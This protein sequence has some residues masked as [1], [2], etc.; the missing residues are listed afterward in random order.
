MRLFIRIVDGQP[1]EHPI[2]EDNMQMAFPE[3]NLDD[4]GPNFAL[5]ERYNMSSLNVDQFTQN[6]LRFDYVWQ[7]DKVVEVPVIVDKTEQE[8]TDFIESIKTDFYNNTKYY[9][10]T[11]DETTKRFVPPIP[12][13]EDEGKYIWNEEEQTWDTFSLES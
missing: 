4:P 2:I 8:K 7:D 9:S 13:P 5:F 6:L 11:F 12:K 10:W 1:F 3:V